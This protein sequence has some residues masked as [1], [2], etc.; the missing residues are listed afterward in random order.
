MDINSLKNIIQYKGETKNTLTGYQGIVWK[1]KRENN[2][3]LVL[4]L[5]SPS[6]SAPSKRQKTPTLAEE[7]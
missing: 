3:K 6:K 1:E 5:S 2:I 4:L 7:Y